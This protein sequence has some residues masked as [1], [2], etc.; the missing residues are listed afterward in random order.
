MGTEHEPSAASHHVELDL[1]CDGA[2]LLWRAELRAA[3]TAP[4][5]AFFRRPWR[6]AEIE[7]MGARVAR[8]IEHANGCGRFGAEGADELR[9]AGALLFDDLLS[10]EL[11]A[12]LRELGGGVLS[13]SLSEA[14]LAVPWELLHDGVGYL[15]ERWRIGRLV[16]CT[17]LPPRVPARTE[18]TAG[19][20]RSLSALV[21]ADPV[22]DLPEAYNEGVAIRALLEGR[23]GVEVTFRSTSVT[24]DDVRE[25]LREHDLLHVAGHV[26]AAGLRLRDGHLTPADV[27]RMAGGRALPGLVFLN[28]CAAAGGGAAGRGLARAFLRAGVGHCLGPLYDV[29]DAIGRELAVAFY[30]ALEP[31][32]AVGSA[33]AV[34]RASVVSRLG[35]RAALWAT[36]A[37]YGA[38]DGALRCWE[39]PEPAPSEVSAERAGPLP[40]PDTSSHGIPIAAPIV[41]THTSTRIVAGS[42]VRRALALPAPSSG[43]L[44][45]PLLATLA[46]LL[47][48]PIVA[49]SWMTASAP[50]PARAARVAAL[51]AGPPATAGVEAASPAVPRG[52]GT[53]DVL[54]YHFLVS[55]EDETIRPLVDGQPLGPG[56]RL[57]LDVLLRRTA[58]LYVFRVGPSRLELL[59]RG[60]GE[61]AGGGAQAGSGTGSSPEGTA[62]LVRLALPGADGGW[63]P[64]ESGYHTLLV[65]APEA[66]WEDVAGLVAYLNDVL[67]RAPE[68]AG[69]WHD[70]R[71]LR[72]VRDALERRGAEVYTARYE[73][74]IWE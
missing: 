13:L 63:E 62:E 36:Y 17:E 49:L 3:R 40:A 21:L 20:G 19:A 18:P 54:T 10:A 64:G 58:H 31:G 35:A 27:E 57:Q 53:R 29:P 46:A 66:P 25:L 43:P 44:S 41:A 2:D 33:L 50:E 74:R 52:R 23:S 72:V 70:E 68:D 45:A 30:T 69:E 7:E 28:G 67:A 8:I 42:Q 56:D 34:A 4:M 47:L 9:R 12:L 32:V 51:G 59:A 24:R 11:K 22:G 71:A 55:R 16:V 37:H 14:L 65:A 26:D 61:R 1:L 39:A 6:R 73:A 60:P 15:G 38:A 5:R 48:I